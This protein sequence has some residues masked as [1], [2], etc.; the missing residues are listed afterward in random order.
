MADHSSSTNSPMDIVFVCS[1]NIC[2]S[3]M[4]E[5]VLRHRLAEHGLSEAVSVRSAGTGAWHV[6]EPA[7]PRARATLKAHG[8]S[9]DHTARQIGPEH[10]DAFERELGEHLLRHTGS[11][12][13]TRETLEQARD[14]LDYCSRTPNTATVA[15]VVS[16]I[17]DEE[18][19]SRYAAGEHGSWHGSSSTATVLLRGFGTHAEMLDPKYLARN[20]ALAREILSGGETRVA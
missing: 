8:Y 17:S 11:A 18:R 5:I 1:G 13:V 2:R 10:L 20:A 15:A 14:Y 3:P 9:V 4:A 16:V 19:T 12:I 6:G 7:D